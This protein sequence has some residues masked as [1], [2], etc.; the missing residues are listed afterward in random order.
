MTWSLSEC[1]SY[2]SEGIFSVFLGIGEFE[3]LV[4]TTKDRLFEVSGLVPNINYQVR[5]ELKYPY[6]SLIIPATTH[7]LLSLDGDNNTP[8]VNLLDN[9][10]TQSTNPGSTTDLPTNTEPSISYTMYAFIAVFVILLAILI[11]VLL[12][13]V[14]IVCAMKRR[15]KSNV[16]TC[17]H[18]LQLP[19]T[20]ENDVVNNMYAMGSCNTSSLCTKS[21]EV[22][23]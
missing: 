2:D 23:K 21:V 17:K 22:S 6:S 4:G 20:Y 12:I 9:T 14:F 13:C 1:N 8:D 15:G 16:N 11:L 10:D 7:H 19:N 5:V 3:I 18:Q